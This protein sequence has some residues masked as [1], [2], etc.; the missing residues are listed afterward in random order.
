MKILQKITSD[1]KV[2]IIL[3]LLLMCLGCGCLLVVR[4]AITREFYFLFLAGNLLLALIPL[5]IAYRLY[6]YEE[7]YPRRLFLILSMAILW[8][9]FLPNAPYIITDFIHLRPE[10]DI[11]MW[12][13][14]LLIF[15]FAMAGLLAGLISVYFVHQVFKKYIST[16]F[17][18]MIIGLISCLT[19][20]GIYLGR[21][22]RWHSKDLF[23]NT[24]PLLIDVFTHLNN[25]TAIGMTAI[26]A[27]IIFVSYLM[28][29]ALIRLENQQIR[30][31]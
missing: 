31:L 2:K 7:K 15:S 13:D 26:F 8:L 21:F 1:T 22:L 5:A 12:F 29:Y 11:P 20:Y 18:W 6:S 24:K 19:G 16:S 17:S 28:L 10:L 3:L 25:K 30:R 9:L 23:F 14:V 27:F 4:I